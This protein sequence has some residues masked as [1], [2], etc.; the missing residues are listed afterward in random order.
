LNLGGEEYTAGLLHDI[1]RLVLLVNAPERFADV[2]G[3]CDSDPAVR[4]AEKE[5]FGADHCSIGVLFAFKNNLPKPISKAI[6]HHHHP[7]AET[8]FRTLTAVVALADSI[9][10]HLTVHRNLDHFSLDTD[11]TFV[12]LRRLVVSERAAAFPDQLKG[13]V[14]GCVRET[15]TILKS[16]GE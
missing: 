10:N 4:A 13:L 6:E 2:P 5:A 9:A 14:V 16:M 15:R 7:D 11:P 8:E 3:G 12:M 1:G